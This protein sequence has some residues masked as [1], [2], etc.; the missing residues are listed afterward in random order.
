MVDN[1][2]VRVDR[3]IVFFCDVP[4]LVFC[5]VILDYVSYHLFVVLLYPF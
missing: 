1:F 4:V 2:R 5:R 3:L